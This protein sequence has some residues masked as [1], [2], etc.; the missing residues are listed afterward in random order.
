MTNWRPIGLRIDPK[1]P[2]PESRALIEEG[3]YL[4]VDFLYTEPILTNRWHHLTV[5][6]RLVLDLSAARAPVLIELRQPIETWQENPGLHPPEATLLGRV[7]VLNT[8]R[9]SIPVL[10]TADPDR[11]VLHIRLGASTS[12]VLVKVATGVLFEVAG[13]TGHGGDSLHGHL[14]GIWILG[15]PRQS[16][17]VG[18]F[19][20]LGLT[21]P[22]IGTDANDRQSE[23]DPSPALPRTGDPEHLH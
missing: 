22:P 23:E 12:T 17:G 21:G 9:R 14:A 10:V 19:R 6:R 18:L 8:G 4:F 5:D 1:A 7:Q 13:L 3:A 15:L 20:A 11:T 16:A 2:P